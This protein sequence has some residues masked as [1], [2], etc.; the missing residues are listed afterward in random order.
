MNDL[1]DLNVG[2]GISGGPVFRDDKVVG[3]VV[4]IAFTYAAILPIVDFK[5][6]LNHGL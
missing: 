5:E 3:I 1:A 6:L 2:P 4:G